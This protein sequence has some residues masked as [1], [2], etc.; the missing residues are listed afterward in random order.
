VI[1]AEVT[2]R[3]YSTVTG[4]VGN[5]SYRTV[6]TLAAIPPAGAELIW[7]PVNHEIC[8]QVK[9]VYYYDERSRPPGNPAV[10]ID[11]EPTKTDS[12]DILTGLMETHKDWE[13]HGGPWAGQ[14]E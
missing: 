3:V 5:W 12:P 1:T 9:R 10:S 14:E 7:G 11:L 6:M 2:Q 4:R 13:Q 8:D